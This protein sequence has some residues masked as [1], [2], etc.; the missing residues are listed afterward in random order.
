MAI[1]VLTRHSS[2]PG[3]VIPTS[4]SPKFAQRCKRIDL[5]HLLRAIWERSLTVSDG[6]RALFALL[7]LAALAAPALAV[8]EHMED[9]K[10]GRVSGVGLARGYLTTVQ[11]SQ[12]ASAAPRHFQ[13]AAWGNFRPVRFK[14]WSACSV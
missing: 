8:A 10:Q 14:R 5:L 9:S 12:V 7:L 3:S 11:P 6:M 13:A 2:L 4:I 1:Y